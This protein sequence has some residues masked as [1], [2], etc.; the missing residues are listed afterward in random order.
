MDEKEKKKNYGLLLSVLSGLLSALVITGLSM[1]I[2][3][4][5]YLSSELTDETARSLVTALALLSVFV[6]AVVSG[7]K[8]KSR[9]LLTGALI[10]AAYSLC[11]YI[12]GFLAF[13]LFNFSKGI[14]GIPALSVFIGALG[15]IVGVNLRSKK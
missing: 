6:S 13:G 4:V 3:S 1:L 7:V 15:G 5:I 8:M 11:L 10:G 9:G 12:T 14:F 2:I